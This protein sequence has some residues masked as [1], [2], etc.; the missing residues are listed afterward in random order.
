MTVQ[1]M[2]LKQLSAGEVGTGVSVAP[3]RYRMS[4]AK[5]RQAQ[6]TTLNTVGNEWCQSIS[7]MPKQPDVGTM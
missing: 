7:P 2:P 1:A 4:E 6:N 3:S 5:D